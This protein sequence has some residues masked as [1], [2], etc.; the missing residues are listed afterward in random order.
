MPCAS[1]PRGSHGNPPS[2]YVL[3]DAACNSRAQSKSPRI[4]NRRAR[5]D[6]RPPETAASHSP[7][8][9]V[10]SRASAPPRRTPGQTVRSPDP[11]E[12]VVD[13][14]RSA[15]CAGVDESVLACRGVLLRTTVFHISPALAPPVDRKPPVVA[16]RLQ[17]GAR[18]LSTGVPLFSRENSVRDCRRHLRP[19]SL[20]RRPP[21][22]A[23]GRASA[24][25]KAA[26]PA[27]RT[28]T[29]E[30]E[31]RREFGRAGS[32]GGRSRGRAGPAISPH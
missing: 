14:A 29:H 23:T 17:H 13:P 18:G 4:D 1:P 28:P 7:L 30:E 20:W 19:P 15:R 24:R 21:G 5:I 2:T 6:P 25:S 9:P 26:S 10:Q 11:P 16:G 8:H 31:I 3:R 32:F 27:H 12:E 22:P